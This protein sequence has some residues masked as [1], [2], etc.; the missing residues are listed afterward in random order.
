MYYVVFFSDV[1]MV[2]DEL[3]WWLGLDMLCFVL[4]LCVLCLVFDDFVGWVGVVCVLDFVLYYFVVGG[5]VC[6]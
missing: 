6:V 3:W 1:E 5:V 2:F 4:L